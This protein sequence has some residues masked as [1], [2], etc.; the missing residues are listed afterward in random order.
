[1]PFNRPT[2]AGLLDQQ[3][4]GYESRLPGA[5]ART[6]RSNIGVMAFVE[7]AG[8]HGL[9]GYLDWIAQQVLVDTADDEELD[10]HGAIWGITRKDASYATGLLTF[11]G[12]AESIIPLGS[13]VRR[14]DGQ[15]YATVDVADVGGT[16]TVSV[17]IEAVTPGV[18][19]NS[20]ASI[21][22]SLISP[23][24]GVQSAGQTVAA[25]TGGS[26]RESDDDYR[27][28]ILARIQAPPHGGSRADYV[29]W[30]K[31]V[32]G[33]TDA[34]VFPLESGPGTVA[35]RFMMRDVRAPSGIPLSGDVTA[36]QTYINERR[37]VTA[38]VIVGAPSPM[39]VN[40]L[41]TGLTPDQADVR[42]AIT[43]EL[44]DFIR[45]EAVPGGTLLISRLREAIST[46]AGEV[47]HVLSSPT[48]NIT[49]TATQISVL[50]SVTFS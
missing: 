14:A 21:P 48:S 33:V 42:A 31:E 15:E 39:A 29:T 10:R 43:A 19:A 27:A 34:W 28:R 36:V 12:V 44:R 23:V 18:A 32:P 35:V 7:T 1:M 3:I 30:A 24:A 5:D 45:R 20:A 6:R 40:V 26:D 13:T 22:V 2:F 25:L 11:T 47:D 46:A 38:N 17:A 41:I 37:P 49:V 9:Y 16:G 8:L 50:G 4:A